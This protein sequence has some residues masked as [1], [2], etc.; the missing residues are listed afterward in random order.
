MSG[1]PAVILGVGLWL[2]GAGCNPFAGSVPGAR[3]DAK[4]GPAGPQTLMLKGMIAEGADLSAA[5]TDCASR[6]GLQLD[7]LR[8]D[9]AGQNANRRTEQMTVSGGFQGIA[10]FVACFGEGEVSWE[11]DRLQVRRGPPKFFEYRLELQVSAFQAITAPGPEFKDRA[12]AEKWFQALPARVNQAT[13]LLSG[14]YLATEPALELREIS[15]TASQGTVKGR[16][17]NYSEISGLMEELQAKG[18]VRKARVEAIH[19]V[20]A[21]NVEKD[22]EFEIAFDW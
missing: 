4:R 11:F 9:P 7:E 17:G 15:L 6:A 18:L 16:A 1:R 14:V 3:P 8:P 21:R 5:V 20:L 19:R 12:G 22:Q 13:A 2:W 10:N